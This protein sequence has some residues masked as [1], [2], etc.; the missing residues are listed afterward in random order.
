MADLC[1]V[2]LEVRGIVQ[3]VGFRP[4]LHRLAARYG[5]KGDAYPD[6]ASAVCAAKANV[7]TQDFIFVGGSSFIV[8]DL[9]NFYA[10]NHDFS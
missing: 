4:F 5:L 7:T 6:V 3:G 8:A 9:L 1:R 10:R 2:R